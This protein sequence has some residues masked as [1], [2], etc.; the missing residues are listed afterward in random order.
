MD[1]ATLKE[2]KT[3]TQINAHGDA[4]LLAA[5]TFGLDKLAEKFEG[6]NRQHYA[7]GE[8]SESLTYD[9]F[10]AYQELM[11]YAKSHMSATDYQ[12]FY[13]LF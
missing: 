5:Q 2:I 7:R 10:V 6:I 9:R 13:M 11:K 12:K 3:L 8:L 4:Y 1:K